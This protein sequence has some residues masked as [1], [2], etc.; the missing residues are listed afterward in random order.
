[1]TG[2]WSHKLVQ[3]FRTLS[4][5][6][7]YQSL[8]HSLQ[9]FRP[10]H[11]EMKMDSLKFERLTSDPGIETVAWIAIEALRTRGLSLVGPT[12]LASS[13]GYG[14]PGY[15]AEAYVLIENLGNAVE[16]TTSIDWTN[17]S[18]E[19][20]PYCSMAPAMSIRLRFSQVKRGNYKFTLTFHHQRPSVL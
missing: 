15:T 2:R 13:Q 8:Y 5:H 3:R 4:L 6:L 16:T 9:H 18:W 20:H 17:P 14:I 11:S 7:Q 1:M 12:G 10:M 19:E